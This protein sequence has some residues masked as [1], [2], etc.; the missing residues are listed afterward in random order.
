MISAF[1]IL[2][3]GSTGLGCSRAL[4]NM[5]RIESATVGGHSTRLNIEKN[6]GNHRNIRNILE[7]FRSFSGHFYGILIEIV[8]LKAQGNYSAPIWS[9]N[10]A[11]C[12]W[13]TPK[14]FISIYLGLFDVSLAP[15]TNCF[16]F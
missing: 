10:F 6:M 12:L 4:H 7:H 3:E 11:I 8:C 16:Y 2:S 9:Y 13:E 5:F 15:K 14:T 1:C